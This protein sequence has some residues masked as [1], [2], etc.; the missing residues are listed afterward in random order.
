[1]ISEKR[2]VEI[3]RT[4]GGGKQ[5]VSPAE[6]LSR[7]ELAYLKIMAGGEPLVAKF[8]SK[9]EWL[10]LTKSHLIIEH[11]KKLLRVSFQ[12]IFLVDIP[13]QDWLNPR[14]KIEG[15]NLDLGLRDGRT[16]RIKIQPGGPFYG[17]MN[18]LLRIATINRRKTKVVSEGIA[19]NER[20]ATTPL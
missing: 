13:K 15:G 1:M 7:E 2:I 16:V 3:F 20:R 12:D 17:L 6:K 5:F 10:V 18:V 19:T 9:N 11:S 14:L 8:C 4:R